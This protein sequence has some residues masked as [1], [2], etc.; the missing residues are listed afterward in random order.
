M[1]TWR[2]R[3]AKERQIWI[4]A[5]PM[6]VWVLVFSYYPMYGMIIAFQNYVPGN[7][8]F[9]GDWVGFAHF[10]RFFNSPDF[11]TIMRNTFAISGLNILFGLPAPLILALL[12][13]EL[14]NKA[15][16]RFT[17]T[18]SYIP[19]FISWVVV[20]SILFTLLGS[21]GLLNKLLIDFGFIREPISFLGEGKYFWGILT[22]SNVWKDVGFNS[23]IYLSALASIDREQIEAGKVDGI[24]RFGTVWHI[25]LPG[26]RTTI[27]LLWILGLGG[28]LNAGFEQQLLIGSPTTAEYSEV[29]DTYVY[30]YGVQLGYYSFAAAVNL[31]KAVVSVLLVIS[32]NRIAKK[33]FDT[34]IL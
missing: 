9:S 12:L 19:Y 6:I 26:I 2:R 25:Y 30:K 7:S 22:T 24:G 20:A 15:F 3:I 29:I 32:M 13:N 14:K 23:I 4:M 21:D 17:Q 5:V 16:K 18:L 27:I 8:F 28:I 11:S 10:E 34:S 33:F 1:N 31:M